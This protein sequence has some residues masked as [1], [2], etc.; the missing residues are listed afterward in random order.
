MKSSRILFATIVF[1]LLSFCSLALAQDLPYKNGSVWSVGFVKTKPGM[2][3]DYLK[4]LAEN[5]KR[6]NEE[7]MKQGWI[8][9]YKVLSGTA[10]N[11]EDWDMM[12]LIEYKNMA[13]L[14]GMDEKVEALSAK[15]M[16]S[17]D[18]RKVGALK[19]NEIRELL[20]GKLVREIILK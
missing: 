3:N 11:Q 10:A 14:D 17:E 7:A 19:R 15:L 6:M 13:A 12:L 20:G 2:K 8:L 9:S 18:Q 16:G 1:L 5:W 4:N